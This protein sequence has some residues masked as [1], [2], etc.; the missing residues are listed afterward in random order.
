MVNTTLSIC[1]AASFGQMKKVLLIDC[2]LRRPSLE[3]ALSD[4]PNKMLGLSDVLAGAT[5]ANECMLKHK[6]LN[7]SFLSAGS[8]TLNPLELLSS[9][10][11]TIMLND[12]SNDFDVIILD[13]P[14]CLAVSDAYV[15]GSQVDRVVLVIQ[16]EKTKVPAIR[17]M[18]SRF[19]SMD[20]E[21]AGALLNQVNFELRYTGN[22]YSYYYNYRHR[23]EK[24]QEEA[25][26]LELH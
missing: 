4:S 15:V 11:F 7:I 20:V 9:S 14:P 19:G 10:E 3:K 8:R 21:F 22:A 26:I 23:Q 2:D 25:R 18:I 6:E 13:T 17:K 12:L 16:A 1:L 24:P 5:T